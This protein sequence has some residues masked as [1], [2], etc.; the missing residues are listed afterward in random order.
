M[1][2]TMLL[3][4][5]VCSLNSAA[6]AQEPFWYLKIKA[7]KLLSSTYD[8][9][10]QVLGSPLNTP[11]ERDLFEYFAVSGG[12]VYV[13]FASGP[14]DGRIGREGQRSGWS[15]PRWT[16]TSLTFRPERPLKIK[17]L[18]I[19]KRGFRRYKSS[20]V[21][22]AYSYENEKSGVDFFVKRNGE[23]ETVTFE[24]PQSLDNFACR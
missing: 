13:T 5:V 10:L 15:V 9:V 17:N 23:I 3:F 14:C 11:T 18:S 12:R 2:W 8:D 20:D 19:R 4:V 1:K 22:G 16:V 6:N 7:I 21:P 24:P